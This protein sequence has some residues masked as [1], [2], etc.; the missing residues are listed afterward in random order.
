MYGGVDYYVWCVLPFG[1]S[2]SPWVYHTLGEAKA[3]FLRSHGIGSLT[4]L[5]D[6]FLT[7]DVSTHGGSPRLQW[8]AA[9]EATCV[10]MLV[11]Y[12]CGY[13]LCVKK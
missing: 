9:A 1:F 11:S 7:N 13:F 3:A 12:F 2:A 10:A 5:D 4:N 6:S 8:L